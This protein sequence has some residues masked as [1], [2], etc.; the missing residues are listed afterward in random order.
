M[1]ELRIEQKD[2]YV[3]VYEND[4]LQVSYNFTKHERMSHIALANIIA[5]LLFDAVNCIDARVTN[6]HDCNDTHSYMG[7]YFESL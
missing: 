7:T 4:E 3:N 5:E 6:L 1:K 2:G